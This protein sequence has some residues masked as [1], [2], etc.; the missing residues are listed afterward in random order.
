MCCTGCLLGHSMAV[1]VSGV[2]L[3]VTVHLKNSFEPPSLCLSFSLTLFFFLTR[4]LKQKWQMHNQPWTEI[5]SICRSPASDSH[6]CAPPWK[7]GR[8]GGRYRLQQNWKVHTV[9]W[10]VF[11]FLNEVKNGNGNKVFM[12]LK[13]QVSQA[14]RVQPSAHFAEG[15]S[16]Q[17]D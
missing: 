11:S 7:E 12:Q 17:A 8:R 13:A 6:C 15:T 4:G 10:F 5:S 9:C 16:K 3:S 14:G 1:T 2:S